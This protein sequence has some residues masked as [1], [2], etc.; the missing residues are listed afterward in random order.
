MFDRV[1][2]LGEEVF[3]VGSFVAFGF[4]FG[5]TSGNARVFGK[6][7]P[8]FLEVGVVTFYCLCILFLNLGSKQVIIIRPK[9]RTKTNVISNNMKC[10]NVTDH[11]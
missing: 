4:A 5:D 2:F 10:E 3:E 11:P 9:Q 1:D 7:F 6:F 8:V